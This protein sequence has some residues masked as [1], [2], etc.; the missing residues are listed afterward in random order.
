MR[1]NKVKQ[2][3]LIICPWCGNLT[4]QLHPNQKYCHPTV[5]DC[6]AEARKQTKRKTYYKHREK[7]YK[8][9]WEE[10]LGQSRLGSHRT[11]DDDE[12]ELKIIR[13]EKKRLGL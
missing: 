6:R 3:K 12:E 10:G 13:N 7:Y 8:K 4:P 1:E 5:R 9:H 2:T 11:T